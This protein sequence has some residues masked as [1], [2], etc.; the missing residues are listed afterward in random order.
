MK[1]GLRRYGLMLLTGTQQYSSD[2]P[3]Y[4]SGEAVDFCGL[5]IMPNAETD[6]S[7][8]DNGGQCYV[9]V[10]SWNNARW[11]VPNK[12]NVISHVGNII[13]PTSL[14]SRLVWNIAK[15][16]N[17]FYLFDKVFGTKI[18]LKTP[19]QGS[20]LL[21]NKDPE[22]D[23]I[24]YTGSRGLWQKFTIQEMKDNVILSFTKVGKYELARDRIKNEGYIL[25]T[26]N[27]HKCGEICV[28]RLVDLYDRN[29]MSFLKQTP[30]PPQF[31]IV[32]SSFG[33]QHMSFLET[34]SS[35]SVKVD[36]N[37][38]L[39]N[40]KNRILEIES[41]ID[42]SN[43]VGVVL[44]RAISILSK[45]LMTEKE[46]VFYLSHGDFSQWNCFS[47]GNKIFVFDWEMGDYRFPLWDYFNFIYHKNLL[48]DKNNK[49]KL[50]NDLVINKQWAEKMSPGHYN[51]CHL[52]YLIEIV[53]DYCNQI[54]LS[55]SNDL[56]TNSEQ[57]VEYFVQS[58]DGYIISEFK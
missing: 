15:L 17:S 9:A 53:I 55:K 29:G 22:K 46:F 54:V 2:F 49:K 36:V 1:D 11:F 37:Q 51:D 8:S 6:F 34:L 50:S 4:K 31:N 20:L 35:F 27:E 12:K 44:N 30:C 25:K 24:I 19:C 45:S 3:D 21:D 43:N 23:F 7:L 40:I 39:L 32:L 26:I 48:V 57:L 56:A 16:F 38:Y 5:E 33:S 14:K 41:Q 47:D 18:Y 42:L 52:A 10:S 13:K 28:P 58:L